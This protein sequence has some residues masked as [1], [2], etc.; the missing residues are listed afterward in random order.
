VDNINKQVK[1][2]HSNLMISDYIT[3]YNLARECD[4][5]FAEELTPDQFDKLEVDKNNIEV[6]KKDQSRILYR[7]KKFNLNENDVIFC[8]TDLLPDLFSILYNQSGFSNI[9]LLTHQ[10]ATPSINEVI[11]KMKPKIISK[12]FSINVDFKHEDLIPIPLGIA[13]EYATRNI[14]PNDFIE[15]FDKNKNVTECKKEKKI[16]INFNKDTNLKKR[17]K[18]LDEFLDRKDTT[19]KTN[20]P[21]DEFIIDMFNHKFILS[22][23]GKGIDTHRFWEAIYL[24]SVPIIEGHHTFGEY[25]KFCISHNGSRS[26]D[27]DINKEI[28]SFNLDFSLL[29]KFLTISYL[30]NKINELKINNEFSRELNYGI[31]EKI[32]KRFLDRKFKSQN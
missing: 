26:K 29:K 19:F 23:Q 6:I 30:I 10:A 4:V 1:D 25:L 9:K 2:F 5:V 11:F 15:F 17:E 14:R 7:T 12:W 24:G 28:E 20:L 27:K 21:L 3:S 16:Y 8:K 31:K 32:L 22:P 13:N 18:I